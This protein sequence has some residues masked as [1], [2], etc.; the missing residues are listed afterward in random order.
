M[1]R[2]PAIICLCLSMT[3][4]EA[5]WGWAYHQQGG[6]G[7]NDNLRWLREHHLDVPLTNALNTNSGK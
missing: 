1:I 7:E 3:S 5:L 2:L 6:F 4:C